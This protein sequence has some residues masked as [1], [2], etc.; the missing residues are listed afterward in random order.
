[1]AERLHE[2][3]KGKKKKGKEKLSK[4]VSNYI[5]FPF[6]TLAVYPDR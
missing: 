2:K 5:R 6:T 4:N 1:M 3:R